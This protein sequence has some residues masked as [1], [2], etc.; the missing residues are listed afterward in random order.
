MDSLAARLSYSGRPP[1]LGPGMMRKSDFNLFQYTLVSTVLLP[2][3]WAN[4]T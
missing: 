4:I 3:F 2:A 1:I